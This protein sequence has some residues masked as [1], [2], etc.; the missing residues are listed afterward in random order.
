MI[1]DTI[2]S[3]YQLDQYAASVADDIAAEIKEYGGNA[4]DLAH[5]AADGS[6]HVI[7]F[8]NAHA[9]CQSCNI[10]MGEEF[11]RDTGEPEGGWSYKGLAVAIA[12]GELHH[13]ILVA[14][15][16]KGVE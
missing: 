9:V 1:S 6:E 4:Y 2:R 5:E 10:D 8:Y 12:Y 13:R 16:E 7:Y 3:D 15:A 11:V 14:L